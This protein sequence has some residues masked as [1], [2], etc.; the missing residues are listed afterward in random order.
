VGSLVLPAGATINKNGAAVYK[1]VTAVFVA[2]WVGLAIGP[3][4]LVRVVLVSTMAAFTG[5][6]VPGSS[7]VTTMTVLRAIG[8]GEE[9]SAAIALVAGIDRP[10][11]MCRT[12]VNT[13]GNLVG[14]A[15][16]SRVAA[17]PT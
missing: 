11:D 1:A 5:A 14:A 9:A 8:L 7:L 4:L 16:V 2:H 12:F 17:R 13:F 10:L 15:V 3:G 6:G